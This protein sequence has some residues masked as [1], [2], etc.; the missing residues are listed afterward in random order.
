MP[1]LSNVVVRFRKCHVVQHSAKG[2]RDEVKKLIAHQ[3]TNGFSL[4]MRFK[5]T[6][7]FGILTFIALFVPLNGCAG[8]PSLKEQ[9]NQRLL[10]YRIN[11]SG[12]HENG[13][14][15]WLGSDGTAVVQEAKAGE[16]RV[17]TFRV[18]APEL[19]KIRDGLKE[20]ESAH[21]KV[22]DRDA[23]PDEVSVRLGFRKNDG[24]WISLSVLDND[25]HLQSK[26]ILKL[27]GFA[28]RVISLK[29]GLK[30]TRVEKIVPGKLT[31]EEPKELSAEDIEN[32][33]K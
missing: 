23:I 8:G 24:T 26:E 2:L 3:I 4:F 29:T 14:V 21:L 32:A 18:P 25:W 12:F 31:I 5:L 28:R 15:V 17:F 19:V 9:A 7:M 22:N 30:P 6:D 11:F 20:I 27:S 16:N 10:L 1:S 33:L 13:E